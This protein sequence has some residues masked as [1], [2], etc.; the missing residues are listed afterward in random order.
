MSTYAQMNEQGLFV[1]HHRKFDPEDGVETVSKADEL[2]KELGVS[3]VNRKFALRASWYCLVSI[4][5]GY[6]MGFFTNFGVPS[7]FVKSSQIIKMTENQEHMKE[8]QDEIKADIRQDR[9][10]RYDARILSLATSK[11]HAVEG[12]AARQTYAE[13]L[14]EMIQKYKR[15]TGEW[16]RVPDCREVANNPDYF[17]LLPALVAET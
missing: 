1:E 17:E 10:E 13:E 6:I 2:M 8:Q 5:L 4:V 16:P 12:S 3:A 11:C 7:P 14:Q 15:L 9:I